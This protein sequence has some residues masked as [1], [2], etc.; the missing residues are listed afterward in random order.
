MSFSN[1][2]VCVSNVRSFFCRTNLF[3][4]SLMGSDAIHGAGF[5]DGGT[6]FPH[7]IG[8]AATFNS[9]LAY[10][11]ARATATGSLQP[12]RVLPQTMFNIFFVSQRCVYVV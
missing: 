9:S 2:P 4:C 7:A 12:A 8:I 1:S 10:E 11:A 6:L 3:V 5:L